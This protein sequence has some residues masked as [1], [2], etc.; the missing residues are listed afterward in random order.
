MRTVYVACLPV[1]RTSQPCSVEERSYQPFV[2]GQMVA[3][4]LHLLA[5]HDHRQV[6]AQSDS[7][8][9]VQV[10]YF[11]IEDIPVKEEERG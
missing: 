3:D 11:K 8:H 1:E 4:G 10:A 9:S 7:D 2:A 6:C 5:R